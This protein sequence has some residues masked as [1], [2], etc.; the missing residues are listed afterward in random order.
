MFSQNQF[1]AGLIMTKNLLRSI[2]ASFT[3]AFIKEVQSINQ[4]W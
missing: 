4:K 1:N 2:D 3:P